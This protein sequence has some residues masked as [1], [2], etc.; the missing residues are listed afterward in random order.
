M[1]ENTMNDL[2][3]CVEAMDNAESMSELDLSRT[4]KASYEYMRE[5]CQNFLDCADRLE[6]AEDDADG[7]PDEAQEWESFDPDC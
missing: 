3:Q 5:L 4:E 6:Q 1:F 2:R 7:Q